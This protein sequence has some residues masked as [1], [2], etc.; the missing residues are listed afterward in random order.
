MINSMTDKRRNN[1]PGRVIIIVLFLSCFIFFAVFYQYHVYFTEQLQIFQLTISHF[2]NYFSKPAFF[3]SYLGDFFTQ[4]YYLTG[5]G[6]VVITSAL[7]LF[8]FAVSQLLRKI[9][10]NNSL[11]LL[12][13]LPV[14]ISWIALCSTEFPVSNIISLIISVLAAYLYISILKRR[15]RLMAAIF[16]LPLLYIAAG[17]N[18]YLLAIIAVCYEIYTNNSGKIYHALLLCAITVFVP[19][20]LKNHYLLTT[21]QAFTY[22][23]EMN[24]NPGFKHF[25]PLISVLISVIIASLP[26][27]KLRLKL[28]SLPSVLIQTVF[29][30]AF[31]LTGLRLNADFTLEKIL[32]LDFEAS[33]DRWSKVYELSQKYKMHNKLSAYYT[34]MALSKLGFMP[35]SLMEHYQPAATGLFIPVNVN[36]NYMTITFSNEVYWQLGDVNASQHSALLGMIFSPRAQNVRLMKRL[37]EINIVNRQ[38]AAA[39]KFI[40]ILGKTMFY[41]KWASDR[42]KFLFNEEECSRSKWITAKRAIIPSKDLL[43]KG[44]EYIKTLRMLVDNHPENRMAVDYLLCYHLLIKDIPSFVKDFDKYYSSCGNILLPE[45]YQEGLLIRIASGESSYDSYKQF[46]FSPDIV[47]RMTEYTRRYEEN[48]GKGNTLQKEFGTTYW[49]YYHFAT[50]TS[51]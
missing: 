15:N 17:S 40:G 41:R 42:K 33:H 3:A 7:A 9:N 22:L 51:E 29:I 1:I 36:E 11:I 8:W 25:L 50:L 38:Y 30:I 24:R 31:L 47:K 2:L 48:N 21:S 35:D 46:R 5:G 32:K 39:E 45:V 28:N 4:F 14:V 10:F 6:A 12:S 34:N 16:M 23:S 18:F 26:L 13:V 20:A 49:F 19:F 27:Q 44:N 37:V 43:K